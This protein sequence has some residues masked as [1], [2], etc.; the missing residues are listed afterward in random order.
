[1][2]ARAIVAAAHTVSRTQLWH[3][4]ICELILRNGTEFFQ[5]ESSLPVG[6]LNEP[7]YFS[8]GDHQLFAWLHLPAAGQSSEIGLVICKPFGYEAICA[9]R[10]MR[11]FAESAVALGI[12]VLRFDYLGTG[13]AADGDAAADQI[14][15]WLQD[16]A[17]AVDELRRRSGVR[18]VCLL[19]FRLGALL[20]AAAAARGARVDALILIAPV[21]DGRRYL[22]ELRT[23]ALAGAGAASASRGDRQAAGPGSLEVSG[24]VLSAATLAR[25][26]E[27]NVS[28]AAQP[29]VPEL[30]II[31][32]ED[33]P[34]ARDWSAALAALGTR[35]RYVVLPGFVKMGMTPPQFA[36]VSRPMLDA[37]RDWL[38]QLAPADEPQPTAVP[39]PAVTPEIALTGAAGVALRERPVF[40]GPERM[41]FGIVT[42]PAS[43]ERRRR[44]VILLNSGAD[45]HIGAG[46]MYVSMARRWADRGYVVLRMDLAGLGDSATRAGRPNDNVFPP[47]VMVDIRAG[48]EF[49]RD[50]YAVEDVT[51]GGLCSAAYHTLRAAVAGLP[52][53]RILMVNP[54]NFSWKEGMSVGDVQLVDVIKGMRGYRERVMSLET[55]RRLLRGQVDVAAVAR[56]YLHRARIVVES[57]ARDAARRLHIRLPRDLGWD[58]QEVAARGVRVVFVFARGEPGI[59]LL[60]IQGGSVVARLGDRCRVHIIDS[61][62]HT[63][64]WSGPRARL[65]QV[66]SEELFAPQT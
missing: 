2:T 17:A 37:V 13:D 4:T 58:L 53:N 8:S 63:F 56:I 65:E 31:D 14:D 51:L 34:S 21:L 66:L 6:G 3:G 20:A 55:W 18:R 61:A 43:D 39:T 10:S 52:V 29:P 48:I 16:V 46:R 26:A 28:A 30:L 42:E 40:F 24:Y 9:H 33:L 5:K 62:D 50:Q 49:V 54:Q 36:E 57:A 22:R 59:E 38:L 1:L 32:R 7:L 19:G 44:G 27:L 47:D 23:T 41:L 12:P 64:T 60:R 11:V 35:V 15:A 45:Y 25:L